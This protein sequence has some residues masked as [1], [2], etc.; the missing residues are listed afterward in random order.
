MFTVAS[1]ILKVVQHLK[2]QKDLTG[3]VEFKRTVKAWLA[4]YFSL[5][6]ISSG[7]HKLKELN[8][9]LFVICMTSRVELMIY[10]LKILSEFFKTGIGHVCF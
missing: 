4:S 2:C 6:V 5:K 9:E 1:V 3:K 10:V 8:L 7:F